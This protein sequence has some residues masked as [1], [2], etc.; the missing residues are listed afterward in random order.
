MK[1]SLK[2]VAVII[3]A[4]NEAGQIKELVREVL[5]QT[6]E[7]AK[8]TRVVVYSDGSSDSTV[9][10]AQSVKD[11]RVEV[12]VGKTQKGRAFRQTQMMQTCT[13]DIL[14][15]LD[16][17]IVLTDVNTLEHLIKPICSGK[18]ELTASAIRNLPPQTWL[19]KTLSASMELKHEIFSSWK[20]GV[21]IYSCTGPARAM[22]KTFYRNLSYSH[23]DGED[24]YTYLSCVSKGFRFVPVPSAVVYYRLPTNLAD[25]FKQSKRFIFAPQYLYAQFGEHTVRREF[26]I[27]VLHYVL[28]GIKTVPSMWHKLGYVL[29][30]ILVLVSSRIL[31]AFRPTVSETWQ[32]SSTKIVRTGGSV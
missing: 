18:A 23:S 6:L 3:P 20:Q 17:D 32:A 14:I 22:A 1:S 21:N 16:A 2:T 9:S 28:S 29:S 31:S 12:V 8:L 4:H 10:E 7:S 19:E 25:Y 24:M 11:V 15:L 30:Y 26:A 27:P 13:S 5:Q